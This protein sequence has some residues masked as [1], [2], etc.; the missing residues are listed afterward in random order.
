MRRYLRIV[1]SDEAVTLINR[2]HSV[3]TGV[4][5]TR[6]AELSAQLANPKAG[7]LAHLKSCERCASDVTMRVQA[8][9]ATDPSSLV[10]S[11]A[12]ASATA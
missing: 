4:S 9:V 1:G 2:N 12:V 5:A 10:L 11:P 7:P 3:E 6:R 8:R